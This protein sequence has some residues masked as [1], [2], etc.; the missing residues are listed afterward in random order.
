[1]SPYLG[2]MLSFR[3]AVPGKSGPSNVRAFIERNA[4]ALLSPHLDPLDR[5][6]DR[7][8]VD[9]VR[10]A[11]TRGLSKTARSRPVAEP[12]TRLGTR[13]LH[14]T[15]R[16]LSLAPE[17]AVLSPEY[18]RGR[19]CVGAHPE[20]QDMRAEQPV[21]TENRRLTRPTDSPTLGPA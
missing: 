21:A 10:A 7:W 19:Y 17:G 9:L 8:L 2:A 1:V 3:I 4:I 18:R 5:T 14:R 16:R 6:I 12:E 11:D 20:F 15:A 13:R